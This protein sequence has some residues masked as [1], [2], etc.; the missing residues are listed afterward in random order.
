MSGAANEIVNRRTGQHMRFLVNDGAL[1]RIET[2][3]PPGPAEP[4]HVHPLQE[5]SAELKAGALHFSVR[6]K[7]RVVRA[8]E[9]I[10][11]PANTPHNFWS[12][13]PE[14]AVVIQEFRPAGRTE[15]FFRMYF[16]L[17]NDG[18][19]DEH[20]VPSLLQL[21]M[22]VPEL[23]DVIRLTR[24][25]WTLLRILAFLLR[26]IARLRGYKASY[27]QYLAPGVP[28]RRSVEG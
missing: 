5:S 4:E 7:V 8:G 9:K 10:V 11:I 6:G 2:I 26:P 16:G 24:P 20:G 13:G 22:L 25:P 17:A 1:L 12:E 3:N 19:T 23:G 15:E 21:A 18:K 14:E 28:E 27:P